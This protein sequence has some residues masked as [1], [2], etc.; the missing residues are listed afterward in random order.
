MKSINGKRQRESMLCVTFMS[1]ICIWKLLVLNKKKIRILCVVCVSNDVPIIQKLSERNQAS[2]EKLRENMKNGGRCCIPLHARK[3]IIKHQK[4]EYVNVLIRNGGGKSG[5]APAR[6]HYGG[7][8]REAEICRAP[9]R[10]REESA[11]AVAVSQ[12]ILKAQLF[13]QHLV[14]GREVSAWRRWHACGVNK[15]AINISEATN[16]ICIYHLGM[17][18]LLPYGA[19]IEKCSVSPLRRRNKL[20]ISSKAKA[21]RRYQ[22]NQNK[23]RR[24]VGWAKAVPW[25]REA[26]KIARCRERNNYLRVCER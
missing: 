2:R 3:E 19:A 6:R 22:N 15:L 4:A 1:N 26:A 14:P 18:S 21:K 20:R 12:A 9:R 11:A 5:E 13:W 16:N 7:I 8:S 23:R 17:I 25:R 24:L 10:W